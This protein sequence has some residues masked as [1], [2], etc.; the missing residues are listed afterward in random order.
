MIAK[1]MT[2]QAEKA[3]PGAQAAESAPPDVN[4]GRNL[5]FPLNSAGRS[6]DRAAGS[7]KESQ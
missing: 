1:A 6:A 4:S 3:N 5:S 2:A 7:E